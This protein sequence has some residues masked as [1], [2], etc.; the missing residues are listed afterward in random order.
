[1]IEICLFWGIILTSRHLQKRGF[2]KLSRFGPHWLGRAFARQRYWVLAVFLAPILLSWVYGRFI[3][4]K[5][6][7]GEVR[8]FQILRVADTTYIGDTLDYGDANQYTKRVKYGADP[9]FYSITY[10]GDQRDRFAIGHL[11]R[12]RSTPVIPANHRDTGAGCLR[13]LSAEEIPDEVVVGSITGELV[14]A[15]GDSYDIAS[16]LTI[17]TD[18]GV[19]HLSICNDNFDSFSFEFLSTAGSQDTKRR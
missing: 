8:P 15:K 16:K 3:R 18:A 10:C 5:D 11:Y 4:D 9:F 14:A 7:A 19:E 13:I 1:M 17:K 6:V 12:V 2:S